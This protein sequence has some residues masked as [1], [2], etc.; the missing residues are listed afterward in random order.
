MTLKQFIYSFLA[1]EWID[2]P[3]LAEELYKFKSTVWKDILSLSKL[4]P[5]DKDPFTW[6]LTRYCIDNGL[7][8]TD[9]ERLINIL[10]DKLK[11]DKVR[12]EFDEEYVEYGFLPI[13]SGGRGEEF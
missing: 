5:K 8:V 6:A 2:N 9:L 7:D 10:T 11:W 12:R 1:M 4:A 3:V 13:E